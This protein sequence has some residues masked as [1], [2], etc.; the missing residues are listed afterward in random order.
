M[1]EGTYQ[2]SRDDKW[3]RGLIH[4]HEH[5]DFATWFGFSDFRLCVVCRVVEPICS[6]SSNYQ[7]DG[8][9]NSNLHYH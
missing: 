3:D 7:T 5:Q 2:I 8:S 6:K 9:S 4:H 1:E